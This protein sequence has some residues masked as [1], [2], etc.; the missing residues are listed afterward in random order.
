MDDTWV[1]GPLPTVLLVLLAGLQ[2]VSV[3]EVKL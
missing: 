3:W 2:Q 1:P